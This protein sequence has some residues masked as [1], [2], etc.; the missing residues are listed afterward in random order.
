MKTTLTA[1]ITL[2]LAAAAAAFPY[3]E[4]IEYYSVSSS[5]K[6]CD[7]NPCQYHSVFVDSFGGTWDVTGKRVGAGG[8]YTDSFKGTVTDTAIEGTFGPADF[9][10]ISESGLACLHEFIDCEDFS[11]TISR[12][13]VTGWATYTYP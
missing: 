7:R 4:T 9:E 3:S 5:T 1:M 8:T 10:W 12:G 11:V 2:A 13:R 6:W